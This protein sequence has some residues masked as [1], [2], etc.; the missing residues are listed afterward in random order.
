MASQMV[1]QL[2]L[3]Q[4]ELRI[5]AADIL[6]VT[7]AGLCHDIGHGPFSH[8]FEQIVNYIRNEMQGSLLPLSL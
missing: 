2:A 8:L 5:S 7:I 6:C 3:H 1:Q 4:P